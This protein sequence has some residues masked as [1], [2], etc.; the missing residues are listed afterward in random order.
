MLMIALA[1]TGCGRGGPPVDPILALSTQ[2]A[3]DRGTQLMEEG[4]YN[5]AHKF[6]SHAFESSPNSR[7][8]RGALLRSA[9]AL[10]LAGGIDNYVLCEAKYRDFINRFPTSEQADYAHF[11]VANCLAER[12]EKPDRDQDEAYKAL[13]AYEELFRLFPTSDRLEE[14][15]ERADAVRNQLAASEVMV[16][17]F[18]VRY[19]LCRAAINRLEPVPEAYPSFSDRERLLFFLCRAYLQCRQIDQASDVL[20]EMTRDFPDSKYLGKL[21]KL[22]ETSRKK[23]QQEG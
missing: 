8:G 11:Q 19:R 1:V 18:Y 15:K 2:E 20:A 17:S 4:K 6:L 10:Y 23:S 12:M 3:L 7:E 5:R 14:A 9:D 21:Q 13:E 22:L 16:G